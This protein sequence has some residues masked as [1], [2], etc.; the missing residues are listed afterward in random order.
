MSKAER[1]ELEG[2][3]LTIA[4]LRDEIASLKKSHAEEAEKLKKEEAQ[5]K[6]YAEM[7]GRNAQKAEQEL[8][9]CHAL[10]DGLPNA[11]L[12]ETE[13][14]ESW[15]RKPIPLTTR[16]AMWIANVAFGSALDKG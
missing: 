4:S 12:R 13:G 2:K 16:L 9:A 7:L 6:S 11:P 14:T 5:Q 3:T 10:L 8:D 15:Q 1:A